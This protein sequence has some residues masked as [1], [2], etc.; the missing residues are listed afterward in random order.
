MEVFEED[1]DNAPLLQ[2]DHTVIMYLVDPEGQF[3]DYYGQ[4]RTA[5]E[6]VEAISLQQHKYS[7]GKN[8]GWW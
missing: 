2:V 1:L 5:S 8:K 6:V 7:H 3:V 4:N